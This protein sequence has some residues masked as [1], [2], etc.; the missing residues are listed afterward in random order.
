MKLASRLRRLERERMVGDCPECGGSGRLVVSY[1]A[2][3]EPAPIAEGCPSCGAVYHVIV[4]FREENLPGRPPVSSGCT[5][6]GAELAAL[7]G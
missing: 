1:H 7:Y 6:T 5:L 2:E 3:G 4:D